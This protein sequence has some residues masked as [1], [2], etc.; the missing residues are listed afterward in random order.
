MNIIKV[1]SFEILDSRGNPT[2]E[3]FVELSDGSYGTAAVPSG[4]STGIYEAKEL[5]D[6]DP[7]RYGGQGVLKAVENVNERIFKNIKGI[8][9]E[10]QKNIDH[11]L[12]ELDGTEDKSRLGANAILSVSLAAA[13]AQAQHEKKE[14]F[15]YLKKFND[16]FKGT[17]IMP[18]PEMN[19][20]NG[21]K[22]AGWAT[23][24]QEYMIFPVKAESVSEAIRMNTEVYQALKKI[25]SEKGFSVTI[26]D[27]GGFAPAVDKNE[28]P[29]DMMSEAIE[30]AGY[31]LGV[32][33]YFGLDVAASEF[34][35]KGKYKLKRERKEMSGEDMISFYKELINKY[36]IISIEDPFDQDDFDS[37]SKLTQE[38]MGK[39][40]TVGD[41][42]F[43]TNVKRLKLGIEKNSANAILIKLNQIGTLTETIDAINLARKNNISAIVSH[44]SGETSDTFISDLV[45]AMGTGQIKSGAPARGERVAKYNR[46]MKIETLIKDKSEYAHL[47][48][49]D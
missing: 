7:K 22:H 23:D 21:G 42:L 29:L 12:I 37:F 34:F 33:Y 30:K 46:L 4:A 28:T 31:K 26:G 16:R 36:P 20:M 1:K 38:T 25:I 45:V 11:H 15:E 40:Q 44:R 35:E 3:T 5:R 19:I 2:I 14:L 43:V 32:E 17:Y 8:N 39:L 18:I 24:I 27:E 13:K 41:D 48:F 49:T 47:S 10:D 9:A 6:E